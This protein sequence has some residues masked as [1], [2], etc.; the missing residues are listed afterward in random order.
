MAFTLRAVQCANYDEP[1][2]TECEKERSIF[3]IDDIID[4][5]AQS[6]VLN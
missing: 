3:Y 6:L 1:K 2:K 4:H 5:I